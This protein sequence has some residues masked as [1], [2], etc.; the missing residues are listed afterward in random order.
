M[1]AMLYRDTDRQ[2]LV[3]IRIQSWALYIISLSFYVYILYTELHDKFYVGQTENLDQRIARH[4]KGT[5]KFTAPYRPWVL[6]CS[7]KKPSRSEAIILDRKLKN[8]SKD[9]IRLFIEKYS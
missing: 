1:R 6:V 8:L 3:S 2:G 5:E 9:R 7:I 4:N